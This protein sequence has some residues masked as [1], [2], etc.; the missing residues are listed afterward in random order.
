[1]VVGKWNVFKSDTGM[2][3][4]WR[5]FAP[6]SLCRSGDCQCR[7]YPTFREALAHALGTADAA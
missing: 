1:M 5:A 3:K 7:S 2:G 6:V 4:P